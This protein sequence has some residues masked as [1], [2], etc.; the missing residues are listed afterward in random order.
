MEIGIIKNGNTSQHTL[1]QWENGY[2]GSM[3]SSH[4]PTTEEKEEWTTIR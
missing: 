4:D 3:V 1:K 2:L